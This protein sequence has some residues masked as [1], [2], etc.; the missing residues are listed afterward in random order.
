MEFTCF[1]TWVYVSELQASQFHI[2]VWVFMYPRR[3]Q[4][5]YEFDSDVA[6]QNP[7]LDSQILK[8][9]RWT[10]IECLFM[11]TLLLCCNEFCLHTIISCMYYFRSSRPSYKHSILLAI[12]VV[13]FM[14][15]WQFAQFALMTQTVAVFGTYV[16]QYIGSHKMKVVLL[17]QSVSF[18][19]GLLSISPNMY[20]FLYSNSRMVNIVL[21]VCEVWFTLDKI[22]KCIESQVALRQIFV[23]HNET[24]CSDIFTKACTRQIRFSLFPDRTCDEH[25]P[26]V[27]QWNAADIL[28]RILPPDSL[29]KSADFSTQ[30]SYQRWWIWALINGLTARSQ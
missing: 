9:W 19:V 10:N 2:A 13:C 21:Y 23:L 14:L 26:P 20:L 22:I 1:T 24:I 8:S 30:F 4:S 7:C 17:G 29:S 12:A 18:S 11:Y 15:P 16:L 3:A 28:L 5:G 25:C 6:I 27:W